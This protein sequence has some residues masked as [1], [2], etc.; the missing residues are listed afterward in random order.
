MQIH[1][2]AQVAVTAPPC[3]PKMPTIWRGGMQHEAW[4]KWR[5]VS[6]IRSVLSN[7]MR[8]S[9]AP[10]KSFPKSSGEGGCRFIIHKY[11]AL[12]VDVSVSVSHCLSVSARCLWR[13]HH[14]L[15]FWFRAYQVAGIYIDLLTVWR[16]TGRERQR[17]KTE[18]KEN[19]QN[20][21]LHLKDTR[22]CLAYIYLFVGLC[23]WYFFVLLLFSFLAYF[24]HE[25]C[26][27]R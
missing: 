11:L 1:W 8:K 27:A 22:N 24:T 3:N 18:T 25:C 9:C 23:F 20:V 4:G 21:Y 19:I 10:C 13:H 7:A 12:S 17:Q 16:L 2:A 5:V 6:A 14:L 15:L 26:A